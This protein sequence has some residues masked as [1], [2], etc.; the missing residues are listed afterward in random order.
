MDSPRRA[1]GDNWLGEFVA[2]AL[3]ETGSEEP[4]P[5]AQMLPPGWMELVDARSPE[6]AIGPIGPYRIERRIGRGGMGV[7]FQAFDSALVRPVAIKF[8]TPRLAA[9]PLARARFSREGQAAAAIKHSNVVTIHFIGEH[10]GLPY[11]VM[12]YVEGITLADRLER[13][14]MLERKSILRIGLQVA[15]GLAAAHQQGLVHRDIKPANILLEG[16]LDQVKITDFGLASIATE[17]WRLTASGVLLGTPAYMSPEQATMSAIDHRSDLFSLG[18]VLYHLCTGEPPFPGPTLRAILAGV[19]EAEP[20]PIRDLNPD[21][22]VALEVII[23]RLMAKDPAERYQSARQL[24]RVL[25]EGLAEIQGRSSRPAAD[26]QEQET[27]YLRPPSAQAVD[28]LDPVDS[29]DDLDLYP[30]AKDTVSTTPAS[31]GQWVARRAAP[32]IWAVIVLAIG[33]W[34][35]ILSLAAWWR[36]FGDDTAS[37]FLLAIAGFAVVTWCLARLVTTVLRWTSAD[38]PAPHRAG[39]LRN[40]LATAILLPTAG[41][42]YLE[43]WAHAQCRHAMNAVNARQLKLNSASPTRQEVESLIGRKAEY[44]A[45]AN[46]PTQ[47]DVAYRWRGVFRTYIVRASYLRTSNTPRDPSFAQA[48]RGEGSDILQWIGD[49]LE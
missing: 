18:S 49:A 45:T 42:A 46:I 13:E 28:A 3:R 21:I 15:R 44:S 12:E 24:V 14:G 27:G 4:E 38:T 7:V 41:T 10:E 6:Q 19:R 43:I 48:D 47:Y 32:V 8:L 36:V 40:A 37:I 33:A 2:G 29:W 20:R 23:R 34:A 30:R 1:R 9:S 22:P 5:A 35:T 39:V 26:R 16:G 25:A 11:L 31:L 17:P